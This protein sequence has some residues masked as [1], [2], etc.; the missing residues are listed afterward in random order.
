MLGGGALW[1]ATTLLIKASPLGRAAPE[2]VLLYQLGVSAVALLA[3]SYVSG[4]G[5]GPL[6]ATAVA[7][8]IFQTVWVAG[9]TYVAWFWLMSA[10]PASPLQAATSMTPLFGIVCAFLVL[11]EPISLSFGLAALL[12]VGGLLLVNKRSAA[13]TTA[14]G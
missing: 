2:K 5:H 7:S 9:V 4:E 13:S 10:Y 8:M 1:G 3:V 14:T 11:G 6:S 12:V